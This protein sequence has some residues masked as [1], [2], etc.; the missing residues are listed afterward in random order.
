MSR[1]PTRWLSLFQ[2]QLQTADE[3]AQLAQQYLEKDDGTRAL[4]QA[5]PAVSS[6]A[7]VRV[8][9]AAPPW[10]HP[11]GA[12]GLQQ[13]VRDAL[14]SLFAALAEM[15]V[16]QALTSPWQASDA[17]PYVSEAVEY[18]TH[19]RERYEQWLREE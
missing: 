6:A 14:P 4:Q 9:I 15:D 12:Q 18:V 8:W 3:R 17:A 19:T 10:L 1:V 7:T 16:Q 2:D 5:Y 11:L 13:H